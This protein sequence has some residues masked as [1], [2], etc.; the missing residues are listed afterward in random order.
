M[1]AGLASSLAGNRILNGCLLA[2]PH[3]PPHKHALPPFL[4][5]PPPPPPTLHTL[6]ITVNFIT[7]PPACVPPRGNAVKCLRDTKV[8]SFDPQLSFAPP[9]RLLENHHIKAASCDIVRS[10]VPTAS[11][12][13]LH[14]GTVLHDSHT[15]GDQNVQQNV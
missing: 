13:P 10:L 3:P 1:G 8:M 5:F 4:L 15:G 11:K 12:L 6:F 14:Q 7:T 9:P 2:P